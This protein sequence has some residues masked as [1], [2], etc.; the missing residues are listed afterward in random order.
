MFFL[1]TNGKLTQQH[2]ERGVRRQ[3]SNVS[4]W[5][6]SHPH[7]IAQPCPVCTDAWVM[8]SG[9]ALW[10]ESWV[11]ILP[12]PPHIYPIHTRA[13]ILLH[14]VD[15]AIP[16]GPLLPENAVWSPASALAALTSLYSSE[17]RVQALE[18]VW[19]ETH[20]SAT[21]SLG[22]SSCVPLTAFAE[23]DFRDMFLLQSLCPQCKAITLSGTWV[24]IKTNKNWSVT[25]LGD[26]LNWPFWILWDTTG[27]VQ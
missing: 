1:S 10:L 13:H 8:P 15:R 5:H 22:L 19:V 25:T 3:R 9:S 14:I 17:L 23:W 21:L 24:K 11:L 7:L 16:P 4:L 20:K 26:K 27:H 2:S 6:S 18:W 12:E